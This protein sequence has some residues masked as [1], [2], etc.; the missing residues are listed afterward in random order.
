MVGLY[1]ALMMGLITSAVGGRP[2]MIYGA[3]VA[4][5]V[6]MVALVAQHV[7]SICSQWLF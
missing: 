2:G 6:V 7:G 3:T 5:A 4:M 1:A